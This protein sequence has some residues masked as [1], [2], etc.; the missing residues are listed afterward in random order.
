MKVLVF[1][2]GLAIQSCGSPSPNIILE[3]SP[4]Y[5]FH[6]PNFSEKDSER[7]IAEVQKF[8][9]ERRMKFLLSRHG[10]EFGDFNA[11]ANSPNLNLKAVHVKH[12][13]GGLNIYA[14]SRGNPSPKDW[15]FARDFTCRVANKCT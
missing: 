6:A 8:A 9:S 12:V 1:A 4:F 15:K 3:T 13:G 10:P 2:A 14:I 11:S 7:V 5:K